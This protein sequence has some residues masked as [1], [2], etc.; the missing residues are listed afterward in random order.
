M[1]KEEK[2]MRGGKYEHR[3]NVDQ[4]KEK[5]TRERTRTRTRTRSKNKNK[6]TTHSLEMAAWP[7]NFCLF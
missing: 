2:K 7:L 1:R 3:T 4:K 6:N 5:P